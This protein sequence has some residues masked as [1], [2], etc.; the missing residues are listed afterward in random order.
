MRGSSIEK[1]QRRRGESGGAAGDETFQRFDASI[2]PR[3]ILRCQVLNPMLKLSLRR[4]H[5][6]IYH[7]LTALAL[8]WAARGGRNV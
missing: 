6:A 3:I 2:V 8:R 1:A 4:G 7:E 5:L